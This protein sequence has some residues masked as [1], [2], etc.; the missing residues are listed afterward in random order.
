[1]LGAAPPSV[2]DRFAFRRL[3]G[4]GTGSIHVCSPQEPYH[5]SLSHQPRQSARRF[6]QGQRKSLEPVS[7]VETSGPDGRGGAAQDDERVHPGLEPSRPARGV[8]GRRP[9]FRPAH[10]ALGLE[11]Y[12]EAERLWST[13]LS[14]PCY[15]ALADT[16]VDQVADALLAAVRR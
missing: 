2:I 5:A 14:I 6:H 13:A 15:P 11:G 9:V 7:R 12:P 3:V 1:M 16:E 10:R 8:A 4:L